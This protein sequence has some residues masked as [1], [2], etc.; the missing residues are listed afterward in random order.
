MQSASA[1]FEPNEKNGGLVGGQLVLTGVQVRVGYN[2]SV[3]FH[4]SRV[5]LLRSIRLIFDG[6]KKC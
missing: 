3:T 2:S 1:S 4:R 5:F 6:L